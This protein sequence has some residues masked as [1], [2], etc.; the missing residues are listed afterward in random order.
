MYERDKY[1]KGGKKE[2]GLI[3]KVSI[4]VIKQQIGVFFLFLRRR[5]GLFR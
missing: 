2:E 1:E 3:D 5:G 4:I